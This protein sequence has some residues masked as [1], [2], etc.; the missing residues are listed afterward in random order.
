VLIEGRIAPCRFGDDCLVAD[1]TISGFD[2]RP[3]QYICEF[4]DG[5]RF[6]FEFDSDGVEGACA[7]G[8]ATATITIEIAGV[9]SATTSRADALP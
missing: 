9:R 3:Q 5:T 2:P 6:T 7:T 8:S 1:F 4:E